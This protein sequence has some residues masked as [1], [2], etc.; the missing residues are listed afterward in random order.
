MRRIVFAVAATAAIL[1]AGSLL[2]NRAD[3]LPA[4]PGLGAAV[5]ETKKVD[6][7]RWYCTHWWRGRWHPRRVCGW[8]RW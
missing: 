4:A 8:R 7:V 3:A 5:D 1:S 2:A 6:Q